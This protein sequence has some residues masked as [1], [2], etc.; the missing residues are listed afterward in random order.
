[1][2]VLSR[3]NILFNGPNGETFRLHK[4]LM[5]TV[6][7]WVS[8][9]AYF[10]ALVKDGKIVVSE[11]AKDSVVEAK[12]KEA[13]ETAKKINEETIEA[14]KAEKPKKGKKK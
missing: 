8:D 11:T 2:F 10:A 13:E 12:V 1:M 7:A 5:G 4:D 6:P 3:G 14:I 9:S